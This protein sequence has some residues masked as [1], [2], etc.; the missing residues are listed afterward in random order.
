MAE[1]IVLATCQPPWPGGGRSPQNVA[2]AAVGLVRRAAERGARAV[3]LPEYLNVAG[4]EREEALV[5]CD[6]T[7]ERLREQVQAIAGE[8]GLW[9][10]LPVLARWDGLL[11]NAAL[12]LGPQGLVGRYDKVHLTRRERE[13]W[14]IVPGDEY[15]VFDLPWGRVGIMICYDGCFPEPARLLA[16]AGADVIFFPSLQRSY[17]EH[18]LELQVRARAYDNFVWVVR[19]S[20]GTPREEGWAPGRPVGKSCIGAPDGTLA[21]DLG[22]FV[23]VALAEAPLDKGEIGPTTHD[24]PLAPLREARN[25]D[26]RPD[27]YRGLCE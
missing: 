16:V 24:G 18:Q 1:T 5:R 23:G 17:P 22:R 20:Y 11:R 21:A 13:D 12:L 7:A 19:S 3:C 6:E 4:M 15:P 25:A 2:D 10:V 14:G 9:V 8:G 27:T 26:R